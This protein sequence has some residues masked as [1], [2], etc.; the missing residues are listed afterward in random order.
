MNYLAHLFLAEPSPESIIGNLL[1]DFVKGCLENYQDIYSEE[2]IKGIRTHRKI[3]IF[4]DHHQICQQSKHRIMENRKRLSGIIVDICYDHFLACNWWKFSHVNLDIFINNI[5]NILGENQHILPV[6]L[7]KSLPYMIREN[8]LLSYQYFDGI[9]LT[10]QRLSRRLKRVNNLG[11]AGEELI[12]NY[13]QLEADFLL[14]FPE[15]I[16]YVETNRDYF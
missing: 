6:R 5:Y 2:I 12:N 13:S 14:F 3:D 16:T 4:T 7:Q 15:L 10:F 8:W 9:D 11:T 1:G